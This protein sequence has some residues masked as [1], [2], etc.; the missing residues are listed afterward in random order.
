MLRSL[1]SVN[2]LRR[3]L[4]FILFIYWSISFILFGLLFRLC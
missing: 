1:I 3:I 4:S 2:F